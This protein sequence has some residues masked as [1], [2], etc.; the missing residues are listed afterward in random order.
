MTTAK[1]F[2]GRFT[3][4]Y[5]VPL[6]GLSDPSEI[7]DFNG[8]I[9]DSMI[10]G[11]G[12][13]MGITFPGHDAT[14]PLAFRADMGAMQ[15]TANTTTGRSCSFDW[16][17]TPV[18][19]DRPMS[20]ADPRLQSWNRAERAFLGYPNNARCHKG[21]S[22]RGHRFSACQ[23]CA[24]DGCSRLAQ[25]PHWWA[26]LHRVWV[27]YS[28]HRSGT[29]HSLVRHRVER[30]DYVREGRKRDAD[31]PRQ[32]R[33]NRRDHPIGRLVR[34]EASHLYRNPRIP[35]ATDIRSLSKRSVS[36][37]PHSRY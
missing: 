33:A 9:L 4:C 1:L 19:L 16:T 37:R 8:L 23:R 29:G 13:G 15:R 21:R 18:R 5:P 35:S 24:R 10:R 36:W 32:L 17:S 28:T 26:R 30:S 34:R 7:G 31:V 25:Q 27:G 22:R 20:P 6:S 3:R 14:G 12:T 11:G 2:R